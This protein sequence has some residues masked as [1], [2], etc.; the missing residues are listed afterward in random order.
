MFK[1]CLAIA[2]REFYYMWRDKGLRYILLLVPF[3]G[4]ILF[5]LLYSAQTLT[6]I[7]TAIADLDNSS[8]SRALVQ[9]LENTE[10]LQVTA[11]LS[12]YNEV[13]QLL[14]QGQVV[15]GV[16]IPENFGRRV[17]L[18]RSTNVA[19]I[20]DG[21]NMI[22]S[23]NASSTVLTVTRTVSAE[24][25]IKTLLARGIDPNQAEDAY[26]SVDIKEEYW[27]NP[28]VNYAYFLLLGF[29]MNMWQQ[30][31]MLASCTNVIGEMGVNSWL[32]I[33]ALGIAKFKFFFS[34]SAAHLI[35][36]M[37]LAIALYALCFGVLKLPMQCGWGILLLFT[38]T[39]A[40]ALHGLGTMMSSLAPNAVDS[41]RFGMMVALPSFVLSGFT[42]PIEAMP[43]VLQS[44][45]WILPQT[46]FFQGLNYLTFK[47]AGWHF[48]LPYFACLI[49]IA[50]VC[51]AVSALAVA[52]SER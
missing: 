42:W 12:S 26:Q 4:L 30:C 9:K 19:M 6:G 2:R 51:Y 18:G 1:Q 29:V 36:F 33:K 37:L 41:A 22:Y 49:I 13:R 8:S 28:T 16:V 7:P 47:N 23:T 14:E 40:L 3:V 25:G 46:W 38:L 15:V 20:I 27:F 43:H 50:L 11:R 48:M 5:S 21:S 17:A 31:C 52:W 35:I 24:A 45:V 10:H 44:L 39:A 32:Q 34:K